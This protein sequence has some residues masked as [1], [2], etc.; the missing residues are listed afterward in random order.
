MDPV[1]AGAAPAPLA[2]TPARP[3]I[4][5]A[6]LGGCSGCHMSF[7]DM[8]E[9]L[10]ALAPLV[11]LVYSPI[12][13]VKEF[14]R[15]VD[16]TLV[17]GSV[18]NDENLHQIRLIRERTKMLVSFGDCAVTGNVT[19]MRN[20]LRR[21]EPVLKRAYIEN[22]D[23]NPRRPADPGVVPVLLD[24]V[25]PL[26]EVVPVD[27]YLPGCPPSADLIHFVLAELVAGRTPDLRD[28][29]KYG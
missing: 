19:A 28:R 25:R 22:V 18:A 9:R 3:R 24:R 21:A 7:L 27:L 23:V 13:D 16:A 4:A 1:K 2:A 12:M 26:H 29:L 20:P 5:S 6:W 15:D 17:E 10:I 14:P 8:D 11:D